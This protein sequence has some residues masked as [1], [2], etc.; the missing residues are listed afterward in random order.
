[1]ESLTER[2]LFKAYC[3]AVGKFGIYLH[4]WQD[5]SINTVLEAAPYLRFVSEELLE[6]GGGYLFFETE[7]EMERVYRQIH[8]DNAAVPIYALTC[9]DQGQ[10]MD[11]NT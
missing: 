3:K 2:E 6:E 4:G 9:N 5:F 11:E 10:L 1:M 7:Q 8:C